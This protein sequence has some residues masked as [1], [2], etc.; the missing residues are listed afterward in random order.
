MHLTALDPD[1]ALDLGVTTAP[2]I[3]ANKELVYELVFPFQAQADL[4][5]EVHG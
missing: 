2:D 5:G 3:V 1:D 4:V